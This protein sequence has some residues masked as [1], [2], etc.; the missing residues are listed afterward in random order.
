MLGAGNSL[1]TGKAFISIATLGRC[2]AISESQNG[3]AP[4]QILAPGSQSQRTFLE[5]YEILFRKHFPQS[6]PSYC[7]Y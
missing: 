2:N 4:A 7:N 6:I 5:A 1:F 3:E